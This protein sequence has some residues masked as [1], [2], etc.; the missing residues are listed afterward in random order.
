MKLFEEFGMIDELYLFQKVLWNKNF[1]GSKNIL[2]IQFNLLYWK[3]IN[4]KTYQCCFLIQNP[5]IHEFGIL[6]YQWIK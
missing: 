4:N 3:L 2:K 6:K 5:Q 1:F